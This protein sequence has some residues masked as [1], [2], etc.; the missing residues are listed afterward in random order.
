MELEVTKDDFATFREKTSAEKM[1]MEAEFDARND[2][3]FN[4]G[5]GCCAFAQVL[6]LRVN[7]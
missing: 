5:C 1:E 3:I 6:Q 2:V 4:Y 7:P